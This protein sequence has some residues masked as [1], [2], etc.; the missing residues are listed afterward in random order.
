MCELGSQTQFH[1]GGQGPHTNK[2][3]SA[4]QQGVIIQLARAHAIA[5]SLLYISLS[6]SLQMQAQITCAFDCLA[7]DWSSQ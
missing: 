1:M 2:Q 6:L 5:L 3:F 4:Y 7:T